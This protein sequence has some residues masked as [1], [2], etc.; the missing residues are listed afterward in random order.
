[1]CVAFPMTG[2]IHREEKP[3][4]GTATWGAAETYADTVQPFDFQSL[5]EFLPPELVDDAPLLRTIMQRLAAANA[6]RPSQTI[7]VH[8]SASDDVAPFQGTLSDWMNP[9]SPAP[10]ADLLRALSEHISRQGQLRDEGIAC[11]E[12]ESTFNLDATASSSFTI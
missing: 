4:S 8:S 9:G 12:A 5:S 2:E 10:V 11:D 1:M 6:G 3:F 7:T